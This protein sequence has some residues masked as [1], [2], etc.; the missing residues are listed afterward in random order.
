MEFRRLLPTPSEIDSADLFYDLR[1]GQRAHDDRPYLVVNFAAT[2]DGRISIDGRSGPIGD[3]GDLEVFRRLRT[4]ADALLVGTGTLR[5]EGYGRVMRNPVLRA[6]REAIGLD[7]DPPMAIVSRTGDLPLEIPLFADPAS[8]VIVFTHP[9]VPDPAVA[10]HVELIRLDVAELTLTNALRR[11]RV[12]HGIRSVLSEGGP[13]VLSALL[14]EGLVDELFLTA[15]PVLAGGG[16]EP[17]LTTGAPL[18]EPARMEPLWVL[19]RNGSLYLRYA[20]R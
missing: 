5:T 3:D 2:V 9:D 4:Q 13:T 7:P 19:E 8:R 6:H 15:A 20:L 17:T 11:L 14:H 16:T 10:A 1:L 12:D 18:P